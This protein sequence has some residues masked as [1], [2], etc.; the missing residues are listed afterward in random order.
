MEVGDGG[1]KNNE[2]TGKD[3]GGETMFPKQK[4]QKY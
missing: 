2:G 1:K 4:M 3:R